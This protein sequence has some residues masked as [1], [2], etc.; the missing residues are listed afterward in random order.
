MLRI[1][2]EAA[3]LPALGRHQS[4]VLKYSYRSSLVITSVEVKDCGLGGRILKHA[5]IFRVFAYL[6]LRLFLANT[7]AK[8]RPLCS[9]VVEC[10]PFDLF[11]SSSEVLD[12]VQNSLHQTVIKR[13]RYHY[14]ACPD[15]AFGRPINGCACPLI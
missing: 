3:G 6:R 10:W 9:N 11:H 13:S 14:S 8:P 1:T 15:R 5:L 4:R 12:G 7:R 2:R